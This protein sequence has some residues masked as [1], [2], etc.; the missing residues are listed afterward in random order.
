MTAEQ[1]TFLNEYV[2]AIV[3]NTY[4]TY[5]RVPEAIKMIRRNPLI[6]NFVSFQA[7][8]YRV[9]YNTI[10]LGFLE[11][12]SDNPEIRKI[13]AKRLAGAASYQAGKSAVIAAFGVAVGVGAQGLVGMFS[14]SEEEKQRRKDIRLFSPD[15][16]QKA[17]LLMLRFGDGKFAFIDVS[18]SDPYGNFDRIANSIIEGESIGESFGDALFQ[19]VEPFIGVDIATRRFGNIAYNRKDTGGKIY[20]E[21]D[22]YLEQGKDILKYLYEGTI[23]PG[24]FKSIRKI[25]NSDDKL[26]ELVGQLTGL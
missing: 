20:N 9:A 13:G 3:K 23:E 19:I 21:A 2:A 25:Y 5:S 1:E 4:P 12:S 26:V 15:W 10:Q 11:S 17:N 16:T 14:D 6:G 8:S 18:S 22:T 24:T 7:E